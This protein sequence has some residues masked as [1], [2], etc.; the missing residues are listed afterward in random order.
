MNDQDNTMQTDYIE[1]EDLFIEQKLNFIKFIKSGC[2]SNCI[3]HITHSELEIAEISFALLKKAWPWH[4]EYT[5]LIPSL[6]NNADEVGFIQEL[7]FDALRIIEREYIV[8]YDYIAKH[9]NETSLKIIEE[10]VKYC[11]K[12]Q[13]TSDIDRL[14]EGIIH[15]HNRVIKNGKNTILADNICLAIAELIYFEPETELFRLIKSTSTIEETNII[16]KEIE[17]HRLKKEKEKSEKAV[18]IIDL[19]F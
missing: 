4:R 17:E 19:N 6:D 8:R 14:L 2:V 13:E 9:T 10:Y 12:L 16:L 7:G 1:D 5:H 18:K 3:S 15:L 11:R